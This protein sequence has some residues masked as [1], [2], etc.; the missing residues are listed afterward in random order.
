MLLQREDLR[1]RMIRLVGHGQLN[2][3]TQVFE[4]AANRVSRYL[5]VQLIVNVSY[6]LPVG[7]AL[8]LIG[9]PNAALWGVLATAL[10]FIPYLG[11][12]IAA[13]LPIAWRLRYPMTVRWSYGPTVFV[14][15]KLIS[16]N[17][18]EPWAMAEYRLF[19]LAVIVRRHLLDVLWGR[20][21]AAR[22]SANRLSGGGGTLHPQFS[23]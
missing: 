21:L 16:N 9:I 13:A 20:R 4:E 11:A 7:I 3:T 12:W 22:C 14:A 6:G 23:F 1:D 8:H 10:R 17:V 18:I 2:V 15:S 5:R 19:T